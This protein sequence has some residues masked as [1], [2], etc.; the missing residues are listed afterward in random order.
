MQ[1]LRFSGFVGESHLETSHIVPSLYWR[2]AYLK[3]MQFGDLAISFIFRDPWEFEASFQREM[4]NDTIQDTL[5]F[6]KKREK[7][8]KTGKKTGEKTLKKGKK[9]MNKQE[10]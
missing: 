8:E 9:N 1:D 7:T 3:I 5:F 6:N 2:F 4:R 10:K